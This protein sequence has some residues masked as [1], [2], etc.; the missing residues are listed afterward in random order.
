M[1]KGKETNFEEN[2]DEEDEEKKKEE[3]EEDLGVGKTIN[4]GEGIRELIGF[5]NDVE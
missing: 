4:R 5:E 1:K 3:E 2:E